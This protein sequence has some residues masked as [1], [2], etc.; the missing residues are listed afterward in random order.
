MKLTLET[1]ARLIKNIRAIYGPNWRPDLDTD[2]DAQLQWFNNCQEVIA[3]ELADT[4][5]AVYRTHRATA[6][7]S[8]YDLFQ[9]YLKKQLEDAKSS[10]F[11][12]EKIVAAIKD[13]EYSDQ[14]SLFS[15]CDDYLLGNVIPMLPCS[16]GIKEFYIRNKRDLRR[17]ALEGP[18]SD[19]QAG[20]YKNLG[21]DYREQ[22][23][24]V[25]RKSIIEQIRHNALPGQNTI[26]LEG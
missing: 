6:P 7:N 12:I 10:E 5:L 20:I 22:L 21:F 11:V 19:E 3:E 25:K 23:T 4:M 14:E 8:P 1:F 15:S 9:T 13:Y 16:K 24:I 17:L 2:V 26:K 18:D